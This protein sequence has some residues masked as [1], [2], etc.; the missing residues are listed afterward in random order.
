MSW[1]DLEWLPFTMKGN[2]IGKDSVWFESCFFSSTHPIS[3]VFTHKVIQILFSFNHENLLGIKTSIFQNFFLSHCNI[4]Y[5]LK[6]CNC[7]GIDPIITINYYYEILRWI[8]TS[9]FASATLQGRNELRHSNR[10]DLNECF[11]LEKNEAWFCKETFNLDFSAE[12]VLGE[13]HGIL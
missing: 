6:V 3:C 9:T 4:Y 1:K 10:N 8:Y 5:P 11:R 7:H 12:E 13:V 2:L